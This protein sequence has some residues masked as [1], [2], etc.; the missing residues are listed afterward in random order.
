MLHA[1]GITHVVS[2]GECALVPPPLHSPTSAEHSHTYN[3]S[4]AC[5]FIPSK[6][7]GDHGSLW[8]EERECRI[9]VLY[10]LWAFL[11]PKKAPTNT[12]PG[13]FLRSD[14]RFLRSIWA[15]S[16]VYGRFLRSDGRFLRSDGRFLRS[17]GRVG[18]GMVGVDGVWWW[19]SMKMLGFTSI[20]LI[21]VSRA[22][23]T[24]F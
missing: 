13:R 12:A 16:Q 3:M 7:P 17:E 20:P 1:L 24:V 23:V 22:L 2:V 21:A 19:G 9:N 10:I 5:Q 6:G 4:P 15:L 11:R 8:I 18:Q 14:G